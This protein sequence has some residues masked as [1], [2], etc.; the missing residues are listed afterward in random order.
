MELPF[1]NLEVAFIL[2]AFVIF[3]LFTLASVYTSPHDNK[4]GS[5]QI[6]ESSYKVTSGPL[7][8][9]QSQFPQPILIWEVLQPT[10]HFCGSPLDTLKEQYVLMLA[11]TALDTILQV[12]SHKSG[13][14]GENH[15]HG[16]TVHASFD[17]S[18]NTLF[19]LLYWDRGA[20]MRKTTH[21]KSTRK[22][23]NPARKRHIQV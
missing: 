19:I 6:L 22:G 21:R 3:S 16:R 10:A 2:L 14:Q 17:A 15:L 13:V 1:T 7:H 9:E 23:S 4:E 8:I 5:L 12:E 11:T 18:P 20:C